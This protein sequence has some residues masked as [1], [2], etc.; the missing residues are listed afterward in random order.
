MRYRA[1][2]VSVLPGVLLASAT[3]AAD[4]YK[5]DPVHARIG[6]TV[7]HLMINNVSGSFHTVHR[8]YPR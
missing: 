7:R 1:V 3:F 8:Q 6:F 5:L 4:K 2:F